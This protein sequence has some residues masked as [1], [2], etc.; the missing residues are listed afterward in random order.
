[1][2]LGRSSIVLFFW[3]MEEIILF[4]SYII[5]TKGAIIQ[6]NRLC[7]RTFGTYINKLAVMRKPKI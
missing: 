5:A 7:K 1:M 6:L 2:V 3:K 4:L